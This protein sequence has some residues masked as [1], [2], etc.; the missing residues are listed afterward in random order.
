MVGNIEMPKYLK[1]YYDGNICDC[2]AHDNFIIETA[3][4]NFPD[5]VSFKIFWIIIPRIPNNMAIGPNGWE[6]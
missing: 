6:V 3:L 2:I 4:K 1:I 5:L